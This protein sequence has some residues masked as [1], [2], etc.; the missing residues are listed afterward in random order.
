MDEFERWWVANKDRF[1]VTIMQARSIWT[2]GYRQA[3]DDETAYKEAVK[4]WS[5]S[6][7]P[8]SNRDMVRHGLQ[9]P[10]SECHPNIDGG[11]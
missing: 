9:L 5:Q 3:Q 4:K 6:T 1:D 10:N 11:D 2:D 8:L 7:D